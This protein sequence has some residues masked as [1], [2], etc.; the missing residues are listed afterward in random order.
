AL[1]SIAFVVLFVLCYLLFKFIWSYDR[2]VEDAL[3][4]QRNEINRVQ[5]ILN[6]QKTDMGVSLVDYAAWNEMANFIAKPNDE[7]I[8]DSIGNHVFESKV[9]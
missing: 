1:V 6:M 4:L 2:A 9:L 5:T 7:F 3:S 8:R